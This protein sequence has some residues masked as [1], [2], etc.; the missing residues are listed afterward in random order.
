LSIKFT[1][2]KTR[3]FIFLFKDHQIY[4]PTPN[5]S[6]HILSIKQSL[7]TKNFKLYNLAPNEECPKEK[8]RKLINPFSIKIIFGFSMILHHKTAMSI[9]KAVGNKTKAVGNKT[10][11]VGNK[12]KTVGNKTKTVGNKTKTV[13]NKTKAVGNKTKT[14]EVSKT[15]TSKGD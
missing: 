11:T 4:S 9:T 1:F 14:V 8:P 3:E 13:G 7:P 10:K 12:T 15:K 2:I 6:E 5:R